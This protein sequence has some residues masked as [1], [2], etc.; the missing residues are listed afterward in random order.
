MPEQRNGPHIEDVPPV[1]KRDRQPVPELGEETELERNIDHHCGEH[2]GDR[3]GHRG[4]G[5]LQQFRQQ[6]HK[7]AGQNGG[8]E[9]H[10][11]HEDPHQK[12]QPRY[13]E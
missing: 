12:N 4:N 6:H 2:K 1:Q 3:H 7:D 9:R 10:S 11:A 8:E 5:A 13:F